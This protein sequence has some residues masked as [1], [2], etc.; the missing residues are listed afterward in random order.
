MIFKGDKLFGSQSVLEDLRQICYRQ[1]MQ[2]K[3]I[4]P[5]SV[6]WR[7][8]REVGNRC[9]DKDMKEIDGCRKEIYSIAGIPQNIV[10]KVDDCMRNSFKGQVGSDLAKTRG[11]NTLLQ[12]EIDTKDYLQIDYYPALYINGERYE[13]NYKKIHIRLTFF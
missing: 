10:Q 12:A 9:A 6:W 2:G 4:T 5:D 13:V 11:E 8:V 7:Y 3:R 1:E